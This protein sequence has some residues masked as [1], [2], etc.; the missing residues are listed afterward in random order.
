MN[1]LV[2]PEYGPGLP[3]IARGLS[4]GRLLVVAALLALVVAAVVAALRVRSG[5]D[6]DHRLRIGTVAGAL[7]V[8]AGGAA[9]LTV[10]GLQRGTYPVLVD[11][12]ETG[13]VI[14]VADEG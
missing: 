9:S 2:K 7:A 8:P 5:D 10:P 1:G 6:V 3:A 13:A 12:R 4:R 14:R 11:G